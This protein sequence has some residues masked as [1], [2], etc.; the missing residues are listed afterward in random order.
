[1]LCNKKQH[2]VAGQLYF[3][4]KKLI[5]KEIR[6]VTRDGGCGGGDWIKAVKRYKLPVLR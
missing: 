1:M 2:S 6:P 5:K 3:K 4:N